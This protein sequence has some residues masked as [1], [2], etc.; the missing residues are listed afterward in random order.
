MRERKREQELKR[1]CVSER[2]EVYVKKIG[3]ENKSK[4][5]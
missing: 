4:R 1:K 3:R 5:E 2:A